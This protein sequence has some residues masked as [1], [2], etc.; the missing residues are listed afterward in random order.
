MTYLLTYLGVLAATYPLSPLPQAH[1]QSPTAI[2][3]LVRINLLHLE[4]N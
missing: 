4:I 1:I 3:K 2:L